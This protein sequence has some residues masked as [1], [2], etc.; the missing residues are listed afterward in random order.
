MQSWHNIFELGNGFP[1]RHGT[2]VFLADRKL[3]AK[4]FLFDMATLCFIATGNFLRR[5]SYSTWHY[6]VSLQQETVRE[7]FPIRLDAIVFQCD[8]KLFAD[9]FL[10]G[11]ALLFFLSAGNFFAGR[12]LDSAR[13]DRGGVAAMGV[14]A[15][16]NC[17]R[18]VS[19]SSWHHCVSWRQE[20]FR[21]EI[22]RLRSK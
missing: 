22:S 16:G 17:L 3:V 20:T 10:L 1:T 6:C 7:R 11:M 5:V 19:C 15:T 12:F 18:R 13:N 21:R 8:R 14:I 2:A 4:G 9:S